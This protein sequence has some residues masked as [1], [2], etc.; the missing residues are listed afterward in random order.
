MTPE[1]YSEWLRRQG[2]TVVRTESSYWHSEGLGVYQAF[3]YHWLI[4]PGKNEL[5]ELFSRHRSVALRYSM[6]QESTR[7]CPSYAIVFEGGDYTLAVMGH[8]TRKNVRKG[9]RECKIEPITFQALVDEAWDLRLDAF[10]RQGRHRFIS[11]DSWRKRYLTATDLPGFQAWGARV[12]NRLAGYAVTFQMGDCLCILDHQ[13][14]RQ[15]HELNINN[16]LTYV[17]SEQ[18][19]S[20]PG[21]RTLFYGLESLDAPERV[22]EFKFHMG[23]LA[24]PIRQRVVFRPQVALLANRLSYRMAALMSTLR[25]GNRRFAKA[26]GMLRVYL[27][28]KHAQSVNAVSTDILET[29]HSN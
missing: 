13:S 18:G 23:Y 24:K 25:P 27:S 7:G 1:I 12:E 6:P 2:Q 8:R 22:A 5:S 15:Y 20:S 16:A 29:R 11:R 14:H 17:V 19:A 10:D 21:V 3:P 9:L 28:E 4:D 26:T